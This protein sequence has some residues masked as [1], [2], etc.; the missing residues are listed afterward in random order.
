MTHPNATCEITNIFLLLSYEMPSYKS[1]SDVQ[2]QGVECY[3]DQRHLF[4]QSII[5]YCDLRVLDVAE[6]KTESLVS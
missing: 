2:T 5:D 1:V 6:M 4:W 3:H